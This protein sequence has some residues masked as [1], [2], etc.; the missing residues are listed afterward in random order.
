MC[1]KRAVSYHPRPVSICS[2]P[3][4]GIQSRGPGD[5]S[6]ELARGRSA[7]Q[8][9]RWE[10]YEHERLV[11]SFWNHPA[12]SIEPPSRR[13]LAGMGRNCIQEYGF[14]GEMFARNLRAPKKGNSGRRKSPRHNRERAVDCPDRQLL[15]RDTHGGRRQGVYRWDVPSARRNE[16]FRGGDGEVALGMD[17]AVPLGFEGR[18]DELPDLP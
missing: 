9:N 14:A 6:P 4:S 17:Q 5:R 11:T 16:V 7:Q 18:C 3:G 15:L 8:N 13:R 2:D 10:E 1:R 12:G